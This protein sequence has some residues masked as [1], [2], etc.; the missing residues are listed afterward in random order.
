M[1]EIKNLMD[2]LDKYKMEKKKIEIQIFNFLSESKRQS[3][4]NEYGL[5]E[6][7]LIEELLNYTRRIE[8]ISIDVED[9]M[10][11]IMDKIREITTLRQW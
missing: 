10:V 3:I 11:K 1:S 9:R 7:N 8:Q 5:H 4:I 6:E 2:T